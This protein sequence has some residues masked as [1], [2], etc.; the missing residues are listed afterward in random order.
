MRAEDVTIAASFER[1]PE[2][3]PPRP[4]RLALLADFRE[5]GW[6]SM[7]LCADMLLDGL[8][9]DPAAAF[10]CE[11]VRPAYR[12]RLTLHP[13]MRRGWAH[14]GDRL[15]NR[16]WDYPRH[17]RRKLADYDFFHVCDHSYAQLALELPAGRT[18]VFCYDLDA[19]RC[20]LQPK[21][22]PRPIWFR[23]MMG[24]VLR[25]LQRAAVV[26]HG[27]QAVR[28]EIIGHGLVPKE[29]LVY[30]PL[31]CA[32]EFQAE[33]PLD[34]HAEGILAT[35]VGPYVLHVGSCIPRKRVDFLLDL[36]AA[37]RAARPA[38]RL[39][40][41]GGDWTDAHRDLI[42]RHRLEAALL[43]VTDIP[44]SALACLYRRAELALLPSEAEGF[45]LPVLE[46]LACGTRV[47]ASDL[48]VLREVGGDAA[49]YAPVAD[50][51]AWRETASRLLD[52]PLPN[53]DRDK[54]L[55]RAQEFT[56]QRH[57]RIIADAYRGLLA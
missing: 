20:L 25:G 26:F 7:D 39:V 29:K 41:V 49:S 57:A 12:R 19:F 40:K 9:E 43:H 28:D 37:L 21:R 52:D 24:R 33:P 46:A 2:R 48:P 53:A 14:N 56:W 10:Q 45:G 6:P 22:E 54:R 42:R 31:G 13:K 8:R 23:W 17:V 30:A 15:F 4:M 50:M 35:I 34:P 27:T 47:L 36:F 11:I 55:A 5:E 38:L 1:R 16:H 3:R 51:P 44:R 32:D 18:G